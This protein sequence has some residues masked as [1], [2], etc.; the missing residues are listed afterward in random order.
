MPKSWGIQLPM[1][2]SFG[3]EFRDPKFDPQ[4]QDVKFDEAK[5]INPN[6]KNSQ[7]YTSRKSISFNNVKKNRN[8]SSEKKP[9]PYDVEN[10][11]VSYAYSEENHQDY[12]IEKYLNQN[13]TA[14]ASYNFTFQ[15]K[16]IEPFKKSAFFGKSKHWQIIR[17]LN[18]N[19]LPKSIGVNSRI[20]RNFV[21][22]KSRNLIDGL[23]AQPTLTQRRFLFDWDY[24]IGFDLTKSLNLNF[25]ANNSYL[26]DNFGN[27][28]E[29]EIFDQFF[30]TGRPDHYT[31]KLTANYKLPINKIPYLSFI[32][33]DYGYTANFDWKA[34]SKSYVEQIGNL[35]QNSNTHNLSST[36]S[37][38]KLYE[39]TGF[40]KLFVK[41]TAPKTP[42]NQFQAPQLPT[43][44]KSKTISKKQKLK[45]KILLGVYDFVTAVK[46]AKISYSENNGTALPGFRGTAGF[47]GRDNLSGGF[48]PTLGFVFGSQIDIR[49]KAFERGWL[50]D[51]PVGSE[52]YNK[53]YSNTHYNKLD[54]TI[55]LKPFKD[56]NI[57]LT[58]NRIRTKN[59][60]QQLDVE[61]G[62]LNTNTPITQSGNFSTSYSMLSTVFKS[63]DDL[64]NAFLSNRSILSQRFING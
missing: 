36:F 10:F 41:N 28:E 61:G 51:R 53:T 30:N 59:L 40:K 39:Q 57:E 43:V 13:L 17:D 60:S 52:Y 27:G 12:N 37:F 33:A 63:T 44:G 15:P 23:S 18:V 56:L 7:D 16:Y 62:V 48:A 9:K 14:G 20:T 42:G 34:T 6:S 64:F 22:Q 3:E 38:S 45:E 26:Y 25:N 4:Y 58:G 2:Y 54:Y 24:T 50:V 49:N 11:S 29:I 47:L 1:S 32:S 31:Q 8:P 35:I 46:T 55:S 5:D 19:L 21:Q